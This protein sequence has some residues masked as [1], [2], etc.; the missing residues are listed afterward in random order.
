MTK[1]RRN[2]YILNIQAI[3]KERLEQHGEVLV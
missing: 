3:G 1:M 2:P